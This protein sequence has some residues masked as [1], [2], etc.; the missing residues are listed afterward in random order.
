MANDE[1]TAVA[2]DSD[3]KIVV[4]GLA[5]TAGSFST[6]RVAVARY[7][8]NGTFDTAF[9][10]GGK[11]TTDVA[12]SH[13]GANALVI[14]GDGKL[15]VA[16]F[17][18]D[19]GA[20]SPTGY[21]IAIV[22]YNADGT[23]DST[24]SDDGKVTTAI[25]Y[26]TDEG[27]AVAIQNDGKILVAGRSQ[28]SGND[29]YALLRY[30]GQ[31]AARP[32]VGSGGVVTTDFAANHDI[33]RAITLQGDGKFLVAGRSRV[34]SRW[35]FSLAIPERWST[36]CNVW[37]R[38]QSHYSFRFVRQRCL[39]Y[40]CPGRWQDCTG[41]SAADRHAHRLFCLLVDI[42]RIE[43]LRPILRRQR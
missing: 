13:D 7:S 33:A 14:Q 22:R 41:R 32:I 19:T 29:N 25:G 5:F 21:D 39:W 20:G 12:S 3:G 38:W 31:G 34:G 8:P 27:H 40:R 1:A 23:L 15:V 9:G 37:D 28:G 30:D 17:A 43:H 16:G 2:V 11:V 36:G 42:S 10:I 6:S 24:F 18:N 35:E 26:S 4:A